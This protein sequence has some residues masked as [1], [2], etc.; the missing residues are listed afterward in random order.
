MHPPLVLYSKLFLVLVADHSVVVTKPEVVLENSVVIL[1]VHL[2]LNLLL[3]S[4]LSFPV[5]LELAAELVFVH[6]FETDSEMGSSN[7]S[8]EQDL[9]HPDCDC[10]ARDQAMV[11]ERHQ[12]THHCCMVVQAV[13]LVVNLVDR[14]IFPYLLPDH[15]F[16]YPFPVVV[17]PMMMN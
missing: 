9:V 14:L 17:V 8:M 16:H 3:Y 15:P 2:F 11:E 1:A 7:Y 4:C 5:H 12:H 10:L 13:L 6:L